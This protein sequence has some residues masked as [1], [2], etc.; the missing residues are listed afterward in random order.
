MAQDPL[1]PTEQT[2]AHLYVAQKVRGRLVWDAV[3]CRRH[4]EEWRQRGTFDVLWRDRRVVNVVV[5]PWPHE[6]RCGVCAEAAEKSA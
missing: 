6:P 3:Y 2:A 1:R 4:F 5:L